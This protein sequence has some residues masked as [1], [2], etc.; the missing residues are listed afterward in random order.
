MTIMMP[1]IPPPVILTP[2]ETLHAIPLPPLASFLNSLT[3]VDHLLELSDILDRFRTPKS[4][5]RIDVRA[6]ESSE[7]PPRSPADFERR[8]ER[9][10]GEK[11]EKR[12]KGEKGEPVVLEPGVGVEEYLAKKAEGE[13]NGVPVL[14]GAA[15]GGATETSL[16]N[17][18]PSAV[19]NGTSS[20]IDPFPIDPS[21]LELSSIQQSLN[22]PHHPE[23]VNRVIPLT[24]YTGSTVQAPCTTS[25]I[26][27]N[28]SPLHPD[29]PITRHD[30]AAPSP[31]HRLPPPTPSRQIRELRL[32]LRTLDAA[33]LFA[34]ETWRRQALGLEKLNIDVPDSIWYKDDS[35]TPP[36]SP[37][38]PPPLSTKTTGQK[39]R[40]RPRKHP[41]PLKSQQTKGY[42]AL[43][44][45]LN[46]NGIEVADAVE[47][48]LTVAEATI[49]SALD[50]LA[51]HDEL[52]Q[53]IGADPN[54]TDAKPVDIT[55]TAED[56]THAETATRHMPQ[57]IEPRAVQ[58]TDSTAIAGPSSPPHQPEST[59]STPGVILDDAFNEK[60]ERDPDFQPRRSN[61]FTRSSVSSEGSDARRTRRG[62]PPENDIETPK[63]TKNVTT[64]PPS[65][66]Q[67]ERRSKPVADT[68]EA[69]T[70]AP[71]EPADATLGALRRTLDLVNAEP[72]EP[73]PVPKKRKM[74]MK[75]VELP[76]RRRSMV[77][78]SSEKTERRV[79]T[80]SGGSAKIVRFADDD[81]VVDK[82]P[83]IVGS[84]DEWGCLRGI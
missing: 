10:K 25:P 80:G 44:H 69:G 73:A 46:A 24:P 17:C 65:R 71:D 58:M 67:G 74:I 31:T 13:R 27:P 84:G 49:L 39:K 63:A 77:P 68:V 62:R 23:S 61:R 7:L 4:Y 64:K 35:P 76:S 28:P 34:L 14:T 53:T 20:I 72:P 8:E 19:T 55:P 22:G 12:E 51:R 66:T 3:A 57:S 60:E 32:D 1:E 26:R 43:L 38:H 30:P 36:P 50:E 15:E 11:G 81:G 47:G 48:D 9:E 82:E 52:A 21:L 18:L 45:V 33:A 41:L 70:A 40:G 6:L 2:N 5:H 75:S 56:A 78:R 59:R 37:P 83:E 54:M 42:E 16:A 79:R 29:P